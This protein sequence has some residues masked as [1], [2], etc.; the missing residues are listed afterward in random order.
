MHT[1]TR[2]GEI[3]PPNSTP[4]SLTC[5]WSQSRWSKS[6]STFPFFLPFFPL[7]PDRGR[8]RV[9]RRESNEFKPSIIRDVGRVAAET[10]PRWEPKK[11][12]RCRAGFP[13]MDSLARVEGRER[14]SHVRARIRGKGPL[15]HNGGEEQLVVASHCEINEFF[16]IGTLTAAGWV[17][18][19]VEPFMTMMRPIPRNDRNTIERGWAAGGFANEKHDGGGE[20]KKKKRK[21]T[22]GYKFHEPFPRDTREGRGGE[23]V[24]IEP[25]IV[26]HRGKTTR[27][28]GQFLSGGEG[29]IRFRRTPQ[30]YLIFPTTRRYR[31]FFDDFSDLRLFKDSRRIV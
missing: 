2:C 18:R 8:L 6:R 23:I 10:L 5:N 25:R 24:K 11:L 14:S 31:R 20:K 22:H 21:I 17:S 4:F 9:P 30:R 1:C 29:E 27:K 7:H 13:G 15:V 3:F 16:T 28:S 26:I 19:S 12:V